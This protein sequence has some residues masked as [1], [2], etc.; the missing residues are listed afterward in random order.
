[1]TRY[2]CVDARKADGF[3]V[4]AACDAAGV[5]TSA[6]YAWTDSRDALPT[7]AQQAEARLRAEIR[8]LHKAS[9]GA[10]GVRRITHR[11][12][13]A[14]WTV[15]RKRVARI[16]RDEGAGRLPATQTAVDDQTRS[17]GA[18]DPQPGRSAVRPRSARCHLVR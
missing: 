14:G 2:R 4:T 1:M 13:R 17:G 11:L 10:D 6:Y 8:R 9:G 18:G 7:A 12:R 15:N 5:S 16:M 3:P